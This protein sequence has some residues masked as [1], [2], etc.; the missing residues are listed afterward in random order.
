MAKARKFGERE[1]PAIGEMA[2][3][4]LT[5]EKRIMGGGYRLSA[6]ENGM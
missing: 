4:W 6:S 3:A 5:A 1:R 2:K